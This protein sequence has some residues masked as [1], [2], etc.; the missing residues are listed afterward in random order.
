M[1]VK[2]REYN[3]STGTF[4]DLPES[5]NEKIPIFNPRLRPY[6]SRTG[7]ATQDIEEDAFCEEELDK[8]IQ[9]EAGFDRVYA[10]P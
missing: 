3:V 4:K 2:F 6:M 7:L 5:F 8:L 9:A 1:T 10:L